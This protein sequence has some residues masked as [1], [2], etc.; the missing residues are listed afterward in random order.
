MNRHGFAFDIYTVAFFGH[1]HIDD[2][3]RTEDTL[4]PMLRQ[5]MEEKIYIDF[6]VGKDGDFDQAV[7]STIRRLKRSYRDDNSSHVWVLA[8]PTAEYTENQQAYEQYYDEIEI[9][10]ES[11]AAHFKAAFQI[12]NRCM[13]DRADLIVCYIDHKS[14]GAYQTIR[15]AEKQ[16]KQIINLCDLRDSSLP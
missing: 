6:L 7:S 13:V 16:G 2:L 1:R 5:L 4:E 14:G 8:Y 10:E 12:R 9:C 3:L 15:Y 11:S